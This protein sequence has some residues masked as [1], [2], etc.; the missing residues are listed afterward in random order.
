MHKEIHKYLVV[1]IL[2]IA[3]AISGGR[4]YIFA[5]KEKQLVITLDDVKL[6]FLDA[7]KLETN[8]Q[9]I[10]EVWQG[11]EIVGKCLLSTNYINNNY[12]YGDIVPILIGIDANNKVAGITILENRETKDYLWYIFQANFLNKGMDYHQKKQAC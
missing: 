4:D 6:L 10:I 3:I 2:L 12:G 11:I 9:G 8:N 1:A 5:D 7:T